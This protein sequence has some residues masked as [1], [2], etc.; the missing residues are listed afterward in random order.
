[1]I[2]T[3]R[4][5]QYRNL[6]NP[7]NIYIHPDGG[8]AGNNWALGMRPCK[9]LCYEPSSRGSD[10]ALALHAGYGKAEKVAEEIMDMIDRE[11]DGS[12]S[13]E[14]IS[15][16]IILHISCSTV[17]GTLLFGHRVLCSVTPLLVVPVR[18]WVHICWSGSTIAFPR[19]S[20]KPI[21]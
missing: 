7:E 17:T 5:S 2:N 11:A 4:Q 19:S 3:I 15:A 6:Y 8:G 16:S 10:V 18:A 20:F 9:A 1:M 14:V 13:L 21:R 12:D